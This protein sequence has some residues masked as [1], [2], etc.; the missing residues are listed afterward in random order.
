MNI[1]EKMKAITSELGTIA[2]N[3]EVDMGKGKSY[4]A[5][6]EYDI[7]KAIK[8]L[9]EKYKIYSYPVD[10]EII[11]SY[12]VE[13]ESQYGTTKSQFMRIKVTYRFVNTEK[14]DEY[15]DTISYGDGIDTSD[16]APGKAMTYADKY[17]LMKAYKIATGDDPDATASSETGYKKSVTKKE[18]TWREK[19]ILHCK[20]E[21]ISID[22]IAKKY[23]LTPETTEA[24]YH[25]VL[26]ELNGGENNAS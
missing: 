17:A 15:I 21:K 19:L 18:L 11:D 4:K 8:P 24:T 20:K 25:K 14:T 1:Y 23:N 7:L 26:D 16:K 2:K 5:V 10:R 22:E 13:K 3:L 9:E 12:I 6:Q